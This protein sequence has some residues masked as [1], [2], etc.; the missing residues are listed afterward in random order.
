MSVSAM[1]AYHPP[2]TQL[3]TGD[4]VSEPAQ[5]SYLAIICSLHSVVVQYLISTAIIARVDQ[6]CANH[7]PRP[8]LPGLAVDGA[9]VFLVL[10]QPLLH[11]LAE[12]QD[13][14]EWGSLVV[15][16]REHRHSALKF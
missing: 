9:H 12:G 15:L 5:E 16:K 14:L 4:T 6:I 13:R 8:P 11:I 7:D 1:L 3:M 10:R 2:A